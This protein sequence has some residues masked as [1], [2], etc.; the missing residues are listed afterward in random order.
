MAHGRLPL[1]L[2]G[3]PGLP[4]RGAGAGRFTDG[5]DA[6]PLEKAVTHAGRGS[7]V[8][9]VRAGDAAAAAC[10]RRRLDLARLHPEGEVSLA[11]SVD[12]GV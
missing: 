2:G 4:R 10:T 12:L 7:A 8:E 11:L 1:A 9:L 6:G 3:Q 5:G